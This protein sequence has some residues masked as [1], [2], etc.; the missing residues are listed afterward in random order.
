MTPKNMRAAV[1]AGA[2]LSVVGCNVA[3]AQVTGPATVGRVYTLHTDRV[4][5]CPSLDWHIVVGP[6]YTLSGMIGADDMN[7]LFN[8]KGTYNPA[9][10]TFQLTGKEAGGTRTGAINGVIRRSQR[11]LVATLGG[12]PIDSPCQGKVVYVKSVPPYN[13][14]NSA[15]LAGGG[16]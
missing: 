12:L 6:N 2:L 16:G 11:V 4:G 7:V 1:I 5:A 10:G 14:Y 3:S 13:A 9:G 15:G 8:V